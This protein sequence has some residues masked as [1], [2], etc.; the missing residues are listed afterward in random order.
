MQET[1]LLVSLGERFDEA[2]AADMARRLTEGL[3]RDAGMAATSARSTGSEV[4]NIVC[5][6]MLR[7]VKTDFQAS[8]S[9]VQTLML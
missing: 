7:E 3:F 4:A 6:P 2:R 8:N 9:Q 5:P 1:V